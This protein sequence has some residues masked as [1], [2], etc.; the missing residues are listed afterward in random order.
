MKMKECCVFMSGLCSDYV[1]VC[2]QHLNDMLE[3]R[4]FTVTQ[5]NSVIIKRCFYCI[6]LKFVLYL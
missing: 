3:W 2:L 6:I 1:E 5:L 4:Q